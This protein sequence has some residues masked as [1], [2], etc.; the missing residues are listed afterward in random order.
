VADDIIPIQQA[1]EALTAMQRAEGQ[2]AQDYDA[3]N[4]IGK[5]VN[6]SSLFG[7]KKKETVKA[8]LTSA[9]RG[10]LKNSTAIVIAEFFK[11]KSRYEK[12]TKPDTVIKRKQADAKKSTD[13]M[14]G[15]GEGERDG[16]SILD[17][18][19][20]LMGLFGIGGA[21]GR[22]GLLKMLGDWIWKGIKFG[23]DKIWQG[24]KN[25]GSAAWTAIKAGFTGV[26]NFFKN[27]YTGFRNSSFWKGFTGAINS[28]LASAKNFIMSAK[29]ALASALSAVGTATK[30]ALSAAVA[31]RP[32]RR[33]TPARRSPPKSK[34]LFGKIGDFAGKALK[35][36]GELIG[37]G[38][39][40]VAD[41]AVQAKDFTVKTVAKGKD[42]VVKGAKLV[43]EKALQ[44]VMMVIRKGFESVIGKGGAN[45]ARFLGGTAR[46]IPIIG[47]AIE[48]LFTAADIKKLK[49]RHLEDPTGFSAS[50]LNEAAGRRA[51]KGITAAIGAAGGAFL[52]G[53]AGAASGPFAFLGTPI[54]AFLGGVSGDLLGRFIGDLLSTYIVPD[55]AKLSIG[56][57]FTGVE[58]RKMPTELQDFII[59]RGVVTPFSE[60]DVVM[61]MKPGGAIGEF[62]GETGNSIKNLINEVRQPK[63]HTT[64]SQIFSDPF[65]TANG[66]SK[67][68]T[69]SN[70]LGRLQVKAIGVSNN[71]LA[72]LV[73]LTQ[74]LV[75]KPAGGSVG[76]SGN[77]ILNVSQPSDSI[78]GTQGDPTGPEFADSRTEFYNSAYSM[79]TPGTLT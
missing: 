46:R 45:I 65:L 48:G 43:G 42:I 29:N 5:N 71:H 61:G 50:Q 44:P 66:N 64:V 15:K 24:L 53:V 59:Q 30:N 12:D 18:I 3:V 32:P 79:H 75:K 55:S 14:M 58:D 39:K 78:P 8:S 7:V 63:R 35:S 60:K 17:Y 47:P 23:G 77:T 10:R 72:Q 57:L 49:K 21:L 52:G 13:L 27:L 2:A 76:G 36:G 9:E 34:G 40:F 54:G 20:G 19:S 67:A 73:Q 70:A 41:K 62:L 31:A 26:G 28:G 1:L 56:R 38:A 74:L 69:L 33:P 22:R 25:V 4:N 51:I 11:L 16:Q 37:S 68:L 6:N